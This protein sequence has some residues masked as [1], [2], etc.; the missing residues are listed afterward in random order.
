M[1]D[2]IGELKS[3]LAAGRGIASPEPHYFY[4]DGFFKALADPFELREAKARYNFYAN[5]PIAI[6]P[7][8]AIVGQLDWHEPLACSFANTHING[9][10]AQRIENGG[11]PQ[12]ERARV[13]AMLEAVRPY[14]FNIYGSGILTDEEK[15]AHDYALA[16]S[17][18]FN[19]HMVPAYDYLLARGLDGVHDDIKNSRAR[20]LTADERDFYDAM[21]L[22]VHAISV[23]FARYADLAQDLLERGA[24]GYDPEQLLDIAKNC[25]WLAHGPARDFPEAVQLVWFFMALVDYD[26]F[27]RADRYLYPYYK[28]SRAQGMTDT[29]AL[30]WLKYMFVKIEECG[31]ILDLTVGGVAP[32]GSDAVNELTYL[33]IQATRENGFRSPNLT[34]RLSADSPDRL[35][36][37]AHTS[38]STGQGLPALYND[39][40]IIDMLTELGYPLEEAR[41]YSLAG[42]SQVI[43][44]GRSNFACDV[45]CYNLL[46][47]LEIALR[48]GRDGRHGRQLGPH[49]GE[50]EEFD[51]FDKLKAAFDAQSKNMTRV[52]VSINNK[53]VRTRMREGACVRSLVSHDCIERGRGFFHGGA[54]YYAVQNEACGITN[55]ADS[56]YAIKKFVYEEH[57]MTLKGLVGL[58][59]RDWESGEDV[60]LYLRDNYAKFGND[61]GEVDDLRASIAADWYAE[62][63]KYAGELG[64]IHWP[65]EVVFVYHEIYGALT[66]ASADGRRSGQPMASSAGASSGL[67]LHGPTALLNSMLKIPQKQCRTCCILNMAF[68]KSLWDENRDVVTAMFRSYFERG[69]FQLQLNVTDRD[70]LLKAQANPEEYASLIVRVGGFSDYFNRLGRGLQ[71]EIIA[72]TEH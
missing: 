34:L 17:T 42:C 18:F 27:G 19:G 66:A 51:T 6:H 56:L 12:A 67:D 60:R 40:L 20:E 2:R 65:G 15:A 3:A 62:L 49:T 71:D 25:A 7:G 48:D 5:V 22:T 38:L 39:P 24:P 69:G 59:D 57:R 23:W 68:Q 52:G 9:D 50:P 53:D 64:G 47:A 72:R 63:Q 54:R 32:D 26:S 70:T 46:K 30:L 45:G 37:E 10:A 16:P 29:D 21:E 36:N 41:D 31:G 61:A 13:A 55:A 43:L 58:L 8:E 35:W 1:V 28:L 4:L 33:I 14:C 11:L 44:P